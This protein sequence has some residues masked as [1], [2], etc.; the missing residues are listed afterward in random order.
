MRVRLSQG[1]LWALTDD[2]Q[3]SQFLDR[4]DISPEDLVTKERFKSKLNQILEA[5]F[6]TT[7]SNK[8]VEGLYPVANTRYFEAPLAGVREVQFQQ[9]KTLQ[10]RFVIP[11]MRGLFGLDR[12][13]SIFGARR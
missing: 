4:L 6:G 9:G 11:G 8:Q 13:M 7:A 12:V 10:T 5:E 1:R 2:I 3:F